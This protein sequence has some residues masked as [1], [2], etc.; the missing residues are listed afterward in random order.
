[1][2]KKLVKIV[3]LISL[4][5]IITG[6]IEPY[7]PNIETYE[8]VYVVD[9]EINNLSGPYTVSISQSF[10]YSEQDP[11]MVSGATVSIIDDLGN[12]ESLEEISSGVYQ[13][14]NPDFQGESG[15]KYKL[16]IEISENTILESEFEELKQPIEIENVYWEFQNRSYAG[17]TGIEIFLDT[18]DP[19]ANSIYYAW[20]YEEYWKFRVPF[21]SSYYPN[22]RIC[23]DSSMY[24]Q[25]ILATT[26]GYTEDAIKRKSLY[27]IDNTTNRL[28]IKYSTLIKQYILSESTYIFYKNLKSLNENV[29]SLFDPIPYSL[30]GNMK[31]VNNPETPVL[32]L[33]QVASI[34]EKRIFISGTELPAEF[35]PKNPFSYCKEVEIP[36]TDSVALDSIN[37]IDYV[38]YD[39]VQ[40][41]G[42]TFRTVIFTSKTECFK[43]T[44]NGTNIK[45]DFWED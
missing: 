33:F 44:E 19:L 2:M 29:G 21:S 24:H 35:Y 23:W 42:D 40:Y 9:G 45:P 4:V 22:E 38:A 6:C 36:E 8:S 13:T 27:F 5:A 10:E 41:P 17:I 3:S 26:A 39:T 7:E 20:E 14:S 16:R 31:D 37:R 15:R 18:Q 34:S 11:E 32:G 25:L 30:E 43:C 28:S 12:R 1:M